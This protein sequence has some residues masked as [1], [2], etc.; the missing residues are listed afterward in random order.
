MKKK[1][2]RSKSDKILTGLCG[3]I[4]KYFGMNSALL[5][6]IVII[7]SCGSVGIG[8]I[9][10]FVLSFIVNEEGSDR[11]EVEFEDADDK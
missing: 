6:L 3:G 8:I 2:F 9:I 1:L 5:R 10:Y 4:A 7:L 11:I